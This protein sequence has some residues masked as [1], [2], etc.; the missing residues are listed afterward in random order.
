MNGIDEEKAKYN[1]TDD[2]PEY[3]NRK[4]RLIEDFVI[5]KKC[6]Y[7]YQVEH[8]LGTRDKATWL[9][10]ANSADPKSAEASLECLGLSSREIEPIQQGNLPF[11]NPND[12]NDDKHSNGSND[13]Y[14]CQ[15]AKSIIL[16]N[17][18]DISNDDL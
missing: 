8:V 12:R 1:W 6:Q 9:D 10:A 3:L 13:K 18:F 14:H 2:D 15:G 11:A 17:D 4:K 5:N 7:Y 16:D